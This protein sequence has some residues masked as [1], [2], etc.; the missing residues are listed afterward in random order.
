MTVRSREN[1]DYFIE[2][3]REL[4]VSRAEP[5]RFER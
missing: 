5:Q 2:A 1:N 3:C 4:D